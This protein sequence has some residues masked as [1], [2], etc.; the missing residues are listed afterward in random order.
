M[1]SATLEPATS[2]RYQRIDLMA[3][4][5]IL[6]FAVAALAGR[7][8]FIPKG[9]LVA[10][11]HHRL[12]VPSALH[13]HVRYQRRSDEK[14][15]VR[16]KFVEEPE[17]LQLR[18]YFV[19]VPHHHLQIRIYDFSEHF[20]SASRFPS[21]LLNFSKQLLSLWSQFSAYISLLNSPRRSYSTRK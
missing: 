18:H 7:H 11:L 8:V 5:R 9:Y 20:A 13:Q 4:F 3:F 21:Q 19:P 2:R 16:R 14:S 10:D 17:E 1:N 6:F 15:Y 12:L